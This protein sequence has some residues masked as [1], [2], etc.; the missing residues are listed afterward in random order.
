MLSCNW[1][2]TVRAILTLIARPLNTIWA[3]ISNGVHHY[4]ARSKARSRRSHSY[5]ICNCFSYKIH[6]HI[7]YKHS[8]GVM[9]LNDTTILANHCPTFHHIRNIMLGKE[10]NHCIL[11]KSENIHILDNTFHCSYRQQ[12]RTPWSWCNNSIQHCCKYDTLEY[13]SWLIHLMLVELLPWQ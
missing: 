9:A 8:L 7:I 12:W 4:Y 1:L 13:P 2:T 3:G 5:M 6:I 11:Y 10:G